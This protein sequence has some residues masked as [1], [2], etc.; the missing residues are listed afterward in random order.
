MEKINPQGKKEVAAF[1]FT[2]EEFGLVCVPKPCFVGDGSNGREHTDSSLNLKKG[3][4]YME[5]V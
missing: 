4:G 3:C 1:V 5:P 2:G